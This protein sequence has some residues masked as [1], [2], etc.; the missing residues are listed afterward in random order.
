MAIL[1]NAEHSDIEFEHENMPT[2]SDD[3]LI[4]PGSF[5]LEINKWKK[6][7]QTLIT[8]MSTNRKDE[9]KLN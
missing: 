5:F 9:R 3:F 4:A 6:T 2:I 1:I 8:A 7:R